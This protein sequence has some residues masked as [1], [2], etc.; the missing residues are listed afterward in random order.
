MSIKILRSKHNIANAKWRQKNKD[1]FRLWRERNKDYKSPSHNITAETWYHMK[2]RCKNPN[3][4]QWRWYGG[5]GIRVNY[6]S[7]G[8]LIADIGLRP[9][10]EFS[11]DRIDSNRDYEPGNC[12]WILKNENVRRMR[13]GTLR[14]L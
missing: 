14:A 4:R 12:R 9:S 5:K 3:S 10:T 6:R 2:S 1:Y 8:H 11:I 13:N 7:M